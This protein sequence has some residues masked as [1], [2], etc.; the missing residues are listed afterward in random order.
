MVFVL[1]KVD[2]SKFSSIRLPPSCCSLTCTAAGLFTILLRK[3]FL[4]GPTGG[5][6]TFSL[7]KNREKGTDEAEIKDNDYEL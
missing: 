4:V 1:S 7:M 3:R 2:A 5:L 6:L